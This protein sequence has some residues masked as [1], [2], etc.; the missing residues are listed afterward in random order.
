VGVG[1]G[2][3]GEHDE[4]RNNSVIAPICI[5]LACENRRA[6]CVGGER[7]RGRVAH[8]F[9][10]MVGSADELDSE[11]ILVRSGISGRL[12]EVFGCP[13]V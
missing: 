8:D 4:L 6:G 9:P 2:V 7:K 1:V 5:L 13:K 3:E 10:F 12:S 11:S